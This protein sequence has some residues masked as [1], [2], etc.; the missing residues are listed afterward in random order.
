MFFK[1]FSISAGITAFQ[2][3]YLKI[4]GSF[5]IE[6]DQQEKND[7][8]FELDHNDTDSADEDSDF[9]DI[10]KKTKNGKGTEEEA[11]YIITGYQPTGLALAN[12]NDIILYNIPST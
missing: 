1:N 8:S 3:V 4:A 9:I 11:M 5:Q 7:M 2:H 6:Q 12:I 10:E